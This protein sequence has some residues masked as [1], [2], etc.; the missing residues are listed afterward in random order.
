MME[1]I[2]NPHYRIYFWHKDNSLTKRL[3]S[4]V[5]SKSSFYTPVLGLAHCLANFQYIGEGMLESAE[6]ESLIHSVITKSQLI[7]FDQDFWM[8]NEVHIQE[9]DMYPLEMN[10]QREVIKRD[11][12]IYDLNGKAI[13]VV[14]ESHS[15][16][17]LNGKHID[18][19]LM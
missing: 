5:K 14:T 1:F 9:Q 12:I 16:I 8:D 10:I 19:M 17:E 2:S 15:T 7:S 4:R 11:S 13:K 3:K 6:G 18:I